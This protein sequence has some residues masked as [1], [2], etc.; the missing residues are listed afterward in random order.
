VKS[1]LLIEF[2]GLPGVGKTTIAVHVAQALQER[3]ID[4]EVLC[5]S[6]V[7]PEWP[8][9]LRATK[10]RVAL[11]QL[12][13]HPVDSMVWCRLGAA[14]RRLGLVDCLRVMHRWLFLA[15]SMRDARTAVRVLDQGLLQG[16]WSATFR[17]ADPKRVLEAAAERLAP[18]IP[19]PCLLVAVLADE[20]AW[21]ERLTTRP[22]AQSRLERLRPSESWEQEL[23]CAWERMA[24]V[25]HLAAKLSSESAGAIRYVEVDNTDQGCWDW[26]VQQI[27]EA[28]LVAL[29]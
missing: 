10:A 12:L 11:A 18:R 24:E 9:V 3:G 25:H 22:N 5:E 14:S 1:P 19:T 16:V 29:D 17:A 21:R 26:C 27:V 20:P 13:L 8:P 28:A 7:L 15:G 23:T 2:V 4:V 6:R